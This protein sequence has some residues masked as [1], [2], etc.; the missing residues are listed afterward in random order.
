M[1]RFFLILKVSHPFAVAV[2]KETVYWDD[3]TR[4]AVF[5]ADKNSGTSISILKDN[6]P[7]QILEKSIRSVGQSLRIFCWFSYGPNIGLWCIQSKLDP[8]LLL[9]ISLPYLARYP[10][11]ST[12]HPLYLRVTTNSLMDHLVKLFSSLTFKTSIKSKFLL[13]TFSRYIYIIF[14]R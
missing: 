4:K 2:L 9:P 3:W 11:F 7:G 8:H 13:I 12:L 10:L 1:K 5:Q 6:M 14:Q